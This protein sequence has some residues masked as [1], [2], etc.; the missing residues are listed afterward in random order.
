MRRWLPTLFCL[1]RIPLALWLVLVYGPETRQIATA[2]AI[3]LVAAI[4]D[5]LDGMLARRYGLASYAGYL[6]D[7]FADRV[8]SVACV[9]AA[10]VYHHLPL[11]IGSLAI[12]REFLLL[13]TRLIDQ[14][15]FPNSR[16]ERLHSLV[17]FTVSRIWFLLLMLVALLQSLGQTTFEWVACAGTVTYAAVVVASFSA[18][19]LLLRRQMAECIHSAP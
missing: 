9:L 19:L 18:L 14:S 16:M 7:G 3:Y 8:L 17:V 5:K 10:V 6:V 4:T 12:A 1:S 13:T 2:L 15:W 11:W